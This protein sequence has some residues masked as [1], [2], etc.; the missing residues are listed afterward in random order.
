MLK[1]NKP[2][3][4]RQQKSLHYMHTLR[5][6]NN[7]AVATMYKHYYDIAFTNIMHP[8]KETIYLGSSS[9][10]IPWGSPLQVKKIV[11]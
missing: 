4:I 5:V 1:C 2:S 11:S 8:G 10:V 3:K 7:L 9:F 6:I